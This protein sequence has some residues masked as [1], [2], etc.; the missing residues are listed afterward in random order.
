MKIGLALGSGSARG[1]SHIGIIEALAELDIHPEIVCGTS[2][3]SIVGAAYATGNLGR[4]K[5]RVCALT[6]LNTASYF[7]FSMSIDGFVNKEK[8]RAFF[9]DC[10]TPPGMLIEDLPV[11]YA[12]VATEVSTG[13]VRLK[14]RSGLPSPF[15]V[16]S[17]PSFIMTAG[18]LTGGWSIPCLFPFAVRWGRTSSSPST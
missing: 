14:K 4:L 10:V 13:K 11:R 7:N 1:W 8:L 17:R 5:Q 6:K 2:I 16:C 3:G 9:A 12:S 15:P 18:C